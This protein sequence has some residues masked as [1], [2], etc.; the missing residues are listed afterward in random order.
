MYDPEKFAA[1]QDNFIHIHG[2]LLRDL[3][4]I[5]DGGLSVFLESFGRFARILTVHTQLEEELFFPALEARAP[6]SSSSTEA[7]HRELEEQLVQFAAWAEGIDTPSPAT[8]RE[9]LIR[10][11]QELEAHLIEEMRVVMPAMMRNFSAEELWALDGRIMEFCS[12]EFMQEMMPWW[13]IHMDLEGRVAVAGNMVTG[14]DP[15]FVPVLAQWIAGGLDL[16]AWQELV[17]RVPALGE[18]QGQ[19]VLEIQ[20]TDARDSADPRPRIRPRV[21]HSPV[22]SLRQGSGQEK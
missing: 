22:D 7:P 3:A 12:P 11:Q 19:A 20:V 4:R 18:A 14:V 21:R 2:A 17:A 8:V 10:F 9:R 1:V 13:F 16:D 15:N 5:I 6:G